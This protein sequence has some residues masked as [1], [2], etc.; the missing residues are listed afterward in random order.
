MRQSVYRIFCLLMLGYGVKA[1]SQQ[2]TPGLSSG[3]IIIA[4]VPSANP[5]LKKLDAN[6]LLCIKVYVPAGQASINFRKIHCSINA[7]GIKALDKLEVFFNGAEPLFAV[8]N[9]I[10]T[11]NPVSKSFSIP[12]DITAKPGWNYIWLS[13]TLKEK[14][15]I[16]SKIELHA[17]QLMD[18]DHRSFVIVEQGKVHS[19]YT[20]IALRKVGDDSVNTYRI[21]GI[22]TTDKGTLIA[23]YDIRYKNTHFL[24][25]RFDFNLN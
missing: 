23:V 10:A 5:V 18:A 2:P 12:I 11:I 15:D 6:P 16:D 14:T 22:T 24:V 17:T 3:K 9:S 20:G 21:P 8:K 1:Y 25:R 19:K 7:E 13:A 4:S